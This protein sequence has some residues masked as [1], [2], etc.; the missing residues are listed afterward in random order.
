MIRNRIKE[1]KNQGLSSNNLTLSKAG[2]LQD[3]NNI[4]MKDTNKIRNVHPPI[5]KK[6]FVNKEYCD[7]NLLSSSNKTDILNKNITEIRKSVFDKVITKILQLNK[8]QVN[9]KLINEF[10]K[11]A[12]EN[13][14]TVNFCNKVASGAISKYNQFDNNKNLIFI[15]L[16]RILLTFT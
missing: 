6:D 5:D 9:Q 12:N 16:I 11:S 1:T 10:I 8:I 4:D 13:T 15:S 2:F 14:N 3:N 7:N